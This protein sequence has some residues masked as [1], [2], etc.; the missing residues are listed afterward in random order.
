MVE[1]GRKFALK[2]PNDLK[3]RRLNVSNS[4][5]RMTMISSKH[6]ITKALFYDVDSTIE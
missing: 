2:K 5:L 3:G 1:P 6:R 4:Q